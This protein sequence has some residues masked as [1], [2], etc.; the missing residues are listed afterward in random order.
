MAS[1]RT[2]IEDCLD[3]TGRL[4]LR[5]DVLGVYATDNPQNRSTLDQLD[6]IQNTPFVKVA[7]VFIQPSA[8]N[9]TPTIQLNL[10]NANTVYLNECGAWLYPVGL[11]TVNSDLLG[12]NGILNQD[13]CS[14][15]HSVSDEEDALFD[16]GRNMGADIVCYYIVGD[17]AGFRGCAAHP[18]DRRGYWVGN[19]ATQWTFI[20]E[21]THIVGDNAHSSNTDNLMIS[22]TGTIT[23][24]PPNLTNDQCDRINGDQDMESC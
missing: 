11:R 16:L 20:H 6:R 10:D 21:M 19:S 1:L 4:S 22:N 7:L 2:I 14:S 5:Q 17:V 8:G 9:P 23:N 13:D 15:A 3:K 18:A 12:S 24:P